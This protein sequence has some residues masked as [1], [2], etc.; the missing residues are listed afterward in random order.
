M[1][2]R[3][4][5]ISLGGS[6]IVPE[7]PNTKF[8]ESF[9]KCIQKNQHT[10]KFAVVCGGGTVARKYISVL[11]KEHKN[12]KEQSLAGIRATRLNAQLMMQ[13]FGKTANDTL[14]KDMKEVNNMLQKNSIVFCGA[15]RYAPNQTS[16]STAAKLA[17]YLK[18]DFI[19]L[20]NTNGLYTANPKTN[21][22]A[23]FISKISWT[24]FSKKANQIKYKPG[25]HF[26]LDQKAATIIKE[27]RI[28]TYI[29][30]PNIKNLNN[31]LKG[32]KF[33][34]TTIE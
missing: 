17:H 24:D 23:R 14:P 13:L 18:T 29:I 33:T 19:N 12:T 22:N 4:I 7:Q 9:K 1:K 31:L 5:V 20:T 16:D 28:I 21:N 11:A 10:Y 15:L 6:L 3:V 26:V 27:H 32:K 30:G 25:Q 8:L 34:G 2:K